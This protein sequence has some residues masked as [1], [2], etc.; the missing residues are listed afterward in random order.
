MLKR[1]FFV[2]FFIVIS[3]NSGYAKEKVFIDNWDIQQYRGQLGQWKLIGS[4]KILRYYA[5]KYKVTLSRIS[6]LKGGR[7]LNEEYVF[8]PFSKEY[9]KELAAKGIKRNFVY[10]SKSEYIWP[11]EGIDRITSA[12]GMRW[13]TFHNGVDLPKRKGTPVIAAMD[14][15]V[16]SASYSGGYGNSIYVECRNNFYT[17]Y[18]HNSVMLVKKGDYIR[19]GQIIAFLG[20]TGNSTGNHLHFE[21]RYKNIPLN[22][23]DFLPPKKELYY[24]N[25]NIGKK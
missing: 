3:L 25:K 8:I 15:K 4:K 1:A 2:I 5:K 19:K 12:F 24:G 6:K 20:S 9:L 23:L 10:K 17:R 21:I 18:S 16:I 11:V 14:G 22:P 13:G 7:L